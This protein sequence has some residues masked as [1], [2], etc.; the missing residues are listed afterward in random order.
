MTCLLQ[1]LERDT[2]LGLMGEGRSSQTRG[3]NS[4][5]GCRVEWEVVC[6]WPASIGFRRRWVVQWR[7]KTTGARPREL[8]RR[9]DT[10]C[11]GCSNSKAT[12][13]GSGDGRSDQ[14]ER[15]KERAE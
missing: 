11:S 3:A 14:R 2:A 4:G 15:G 10:K 1:P 5:E 13:Q 8:R 12:K 7:L 6:M 9:N